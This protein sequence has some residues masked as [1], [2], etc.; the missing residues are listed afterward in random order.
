MLNRIRK[1]KGLER[2][3]GE[4]IENPKDFYETANATELAEICRKI[5][6]LL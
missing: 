6:L 3:L 4:L 1:I 2:Q 5:T